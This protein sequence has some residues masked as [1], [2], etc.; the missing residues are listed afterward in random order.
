MPE[1][2]HP[3]LYTE[4]LTTKRGVYSGGKRTAPVAFITVGVR[5]SAVLP[6][7]PEA[8]Q[9]AFLRGIAIEYRI[10]SD[11]ADI[12]PEDVITINGSDFVT[13]EVGKWPATETRLLEISVREYQG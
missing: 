8:K 13:V 7:E 1:V 2:L 3:K 9:D 10:F 11:P 12:V 5:C 4:K 6:L